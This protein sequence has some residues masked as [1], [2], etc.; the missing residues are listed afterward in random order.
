MERN[1]L[2]T[3]TVAAHHQNG[4]FGVIGRNLLHRFVPTICDVSMCFFGTDSS[5]RR[6][7]RFTT[8]TVAIYP[9]IPDP[10]MTYFTFS[11]RFRRSLD[12]KAKGQ[13]IWILIK[14]G[15]SF[16][17]GLAGWLSRVQGRTCL[18][19][20]SSGPVLQSTTKLPVLRWRGRKGRGGRRVWG[21]EKIYVRIEMSWKSFDIPWVCVEC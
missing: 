8:R 16:I 21:Q 2:H 12:W 10:T 11:G 9:A 1:N 7:Y 4:R 6:K 14:T 20:S 3:K 17:L 19:Q 18:S 13:D 15:A 5:C